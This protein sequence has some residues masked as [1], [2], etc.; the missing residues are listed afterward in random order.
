MAA[1]S[2]CGAKTKNGGTCRLGAGW[3]T[4]HPGFGSCKKHFGN[5]PNHRKHAARQEG[6]ALAAEAGLIVEADAATVDPLEAL[7][8]LLQVVYRDWLQWEARAVAVGPPIVETKWGPRL[9]P[10]QAVLDLKRDQVLK[11]A[12][13]AHEAGVEERRVELVEA[14]G[15][16]LAGLLGAILD[17]L[18]LSAAQRERAP[19]IVRAELR[20]LEGGPA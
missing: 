10:E 15:G 4:D 7:S 6:L 12:K 17:R 20:V 1:A 14:V 19:E 2:Q 8:E 13:G 5:A 11:V 3:G 9:R 16:D 18:D